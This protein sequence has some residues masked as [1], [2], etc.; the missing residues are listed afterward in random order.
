MTL[1]DSLDNP[2]P[3]Q[4]REIGDS[5]VKFAAWGQSSNRFYTGGSDGMVKAWDVK[6]P[7]S[8]AFIRNV[9]S[10]SGGV[11]TGVFNQ[12][13]SKLL[14]GDATGKV[15]LLSTDDSDIAEDLVPAQHAHAKQPITFGSQLEGGLKRPKVIV[16]H[17]E[18]L[19]PSTSESIDSHLLEEAYEP[20]GAENSRE[21]LNRGILVRF[22]TEEHPHS[23]HAVF[24][25][26]AYSD[27]GFFRSDLHVD[28]DVTQELLPLTLASQQFL[29]DEEV[30]RL[31]VSRLPIPR[32]ASNRQQHQANIA[33]DFNFDALEPDTQKSLAGDKVEL[34]WDNSFPHELSPSKSHWLW[35][36][37]EG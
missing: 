25:G 16:P 27:S 23:Q 36:R 29:V 5:G 28:G 24:Q 19:P 12:D 3:D 15:Y 35:K 2:D 33:L 10:I 18:P 8:K 34:H 26:P 13:C 32:T 21:Y 9:L 14:V 1:P 4:P 22:P 31:R 17:A 30:P 37:N 7:P 11:S 20:T 6:A